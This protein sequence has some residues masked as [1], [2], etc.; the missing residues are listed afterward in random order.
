[1]AEAKPLKYPDVFILEKGNQIRITSK[2]TIW[3]CILDIQSKHNQNL[4]KPSK[5]K[6]SQLKKFK[7]SCF[8]TLFLRIRE[9][10]LSGRIIHN[11]FARQADSLNTKVMEFNFNDK[12]AI[13]TWKEFGLITGLKM[14]HSLDVTPPPSSNRIRDKYF[15]DIKK[16]RSHYIRNSFMNLKHSNLEDKDDMVWGYE[17][18]PLMGHLYAN[19]LYVIGR[20]RAINAD[21]ESIYEQ[22]ENCPIPPL[23][24]YVNE[25]PINF[26][27]EHEGFSYYHQQQHASNVE[28]PTIDDFARLSTSSHYQ[29]HPGHHDTHMHDATEDVAM[30]DEDGAP[31][32]N[33][34]I[35]EY[36]DS[37]VQYVT[38]SKMVQ[39]EPHIK[40]Q[41]EFLK[42]PFV[43][44]TNTRETLKNTL[45]YPPEHFNPKR[46]FSKELSTNFSMYFTSDMDTL[47]D[48]TICDVNKE[49]FNI[50]LNEGYWLNEKHVNVITML[51]RYRMTKYPTLFSSRTAI[52][53]AYFWGVLEGRWPA[54]SKFRKDNPKQSYPFDNTLLDYITGHS[55]KS[56]GQDWKHCDHSDSSYGYGY[57]VSSRVRDIRS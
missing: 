32:L 28:I 31:D 3:Q 22:N 44:T 17:T 47:I 11:M 50:L 21:E 1:M 19:K 16:I 23:E 10:V 24:Q 15:G 53:D 40:K 43:V 49:F 57:S 37:E 18:I 25:G 12:S 34:N 26:D 14:K 46:D 35:V 55:Y 45:P 48:M 51:M 33:M 27:H 20:L 38:P 39:R 5:L 8:G 13:F 41:S 54:F 4:E 42:S 7:K 30:G 52:M 9:L 56:Y 29:Y 6:E 2:S 36:D